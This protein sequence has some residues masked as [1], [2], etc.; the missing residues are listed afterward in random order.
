MLHCSELITIGIHSSSKPS[1]PRAEDPL[2]QMH[3][4]DRLRHCI[5]QK[6]KFHSQPQQLTLYLMEFLLP[7]TFTKISNN[8]VSPFPGTSYLYGLE[9]LILSCLNY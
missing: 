4:L 6:R 7:T 3:Q 9:L 2:E 5:L 1:V 8:W